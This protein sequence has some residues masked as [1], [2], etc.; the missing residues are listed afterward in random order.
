[1][2]MTN[3]QL[4]L[5]INRARSRTVQYRDRTVATGIYKEPVDGAVRVDCDGLEGDVQVDRNNHGGVDKALYAYTHEN[6]RYWE[7]A[8]G[9]PAY[10][11]G[12]FGENL[13]LSG[14]PD[15]QVCIGDIWQIGSVITQVTQP[16]VPC[17]KLGLK[18]AD[19]GF[20]E[21]FLHSGRTGFYLRVL[22]GGWLQTGD[23]LSCLEPGVSRLS[24]RDALLAI[25]KNPRQVAILQ[26]AL[27][28][29]ALSAAWRDDLQHR[30]DALQK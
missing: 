3:R 26:Q 7:S 6:Y 20:V 1:M 22:Q 18:M 16:R 4:L 23:E 24:V 15:E 9:Q 27:A 2:T 17:F 14:M 30:L 21:R 8:P 28:I 25:I 12:Q 10:P 19:P 11:Y 29:P 5:S 13:T